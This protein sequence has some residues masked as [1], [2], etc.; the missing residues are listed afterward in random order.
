MPNFQYP[1]REWIKAN[2]DPRLAEA[3]DALQ[4][5]HN[6]VFN[7]SSMS[8]VG[9][10]PVPPQVSNLE[11]SAGNGVFQARITDNNPVTMG[12]NYFLEYSNTPNFAA[13]HVV[14]LGPSRTWRQNLGPI[15]LHWR[16]YSQYQSGQPSKPV[17]FGNPANPTPV[18]SAGA[19]A[20]SLP[21]STGSGTA[22]GNGQ[23]G[24][25][26]YGKVLKRT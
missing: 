20:P 10:T 9:E 12:I 6:S 15:T 2:F 19:I 21:A 23:Q 16:A 3:F 11:M 5:A 13:P 24:G 1:N 8:P 14:H 22:S 18:S 7:K 26:G 4:E 17:Y 25:S